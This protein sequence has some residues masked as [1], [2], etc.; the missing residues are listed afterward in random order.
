MSTLDGMPRA[1]HRNAGRLAPLTGRNIEL[2]I[3]L[4]I[5]RVQFSEDVAI[6]GLI[7]LWALPLQD[8]PRGAW[9]SI[10][11]LMPVDGT[12]NLLRHSCAAA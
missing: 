9:L 2:D 8:V 10:D 4:Q 11:R 6:A 12:S 5:G 3:V 7:E 1:S